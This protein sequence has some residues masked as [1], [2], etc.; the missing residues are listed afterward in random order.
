LQ[1]P[2]LATEPAGQAL[3]A[4]ASMLSKHPPSKQT[5]DAGHN[6][7]AQGSAG[8]SICGKHPPSKQASPVGQTTSAQAST[9]FCWAEAVRPNASTAAKQASAETMVENRD[10]MRRTSRLHDVYV[11]AAAS[12][13]PDTVQSGLKP[14]W[15]SRWESASWIFTVPEFRP[16]PSKSIL[17]SPMKG[18]CDTTLYPAS[19][20]CEL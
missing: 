20:R 3:S 18:F 4:G 15:I 7:S 2:L 1:D 6:T 16:L 11:I 10:R 13:P 12:P 8:A 5:C 19:R 17:V 9:G 14:I